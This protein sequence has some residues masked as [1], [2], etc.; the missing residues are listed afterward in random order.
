MIKW[1]MS[2]HCVMTKKHINVIYFELCKKKKI[3]LV[4][5]VKKKKKRWSQK[6]ESHPV[7]LDINWRKNCGLQI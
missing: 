3:T 4:F 5:E 2:V 6:E 1:I 7:P